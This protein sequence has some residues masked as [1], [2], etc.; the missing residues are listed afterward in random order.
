M[1]SI[2]AIVNQKG[3]V[4]KTTVT[5][6]LA[7][8]AQAAGHRTL[9]VDADPQA[10][11]TWAL[12]V[13]PETVEYGTS[14]A[15]AA[16]KSG[17]AG[18]A[19][20]TS[21]WGSEVDLVPAGRDLMS[22]EGEGGREPVLRLRKALT[23]VSDGYEFTFIDCSPALGLTTKGALSAADFVLLVVEPAALSLRGI[24]AVSD[25]ID[26]VWESHNPGLDIAGV[27]VNRVPP[28]S[29]EADRQYE[30]L[31]KMLGR[32]TIWEPAIPQRVVI[33][34]AL[35]ERRPIHSLGYR[36]ADSAETFDKLYARLRRTA[37]KAK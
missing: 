11:A 5:L 36:A 7:S 4:G 30:A 23:G 12:G 15:I 17:A 25:T 3:G 14:E 37:R 1:A 28:V 21:T 13:E 20:V 6:G 31:A 32:R 16:N 34:Q 24:A 33:A 26:D 2:V 8:A 10:S 9:V 35:A 22:R 29:G 27:V 18:K 19:V